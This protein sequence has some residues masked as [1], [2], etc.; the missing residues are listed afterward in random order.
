MLLLAIFRHLAPTSQLYV[1]I[2]FAELALETSAIWSYGIYRFT[3]S[4]GK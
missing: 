2:M 4:G 3:R 1:W